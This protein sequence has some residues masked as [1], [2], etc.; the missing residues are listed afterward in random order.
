MKKVTIFF[1]LLCIF[2]VSCKHKQ[3]P[4]NEKQWMKQKNRFYMTESLIEKLN[5][6]KPKRS[7]I[8]DLLGEPEF[9][10]WISDSVVTYWLKSE[11][12]LTIWELAI[13]F[14]NDGNFESARVCCED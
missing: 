3:M 10:G 5:N 12:F 9:E 11:G 1:L 2:F 4:F 6:E 13:F 8:F 7:E 14:D